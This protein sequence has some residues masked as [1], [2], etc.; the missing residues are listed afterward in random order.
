MWVL[1]F[2]LHTFLLLLTLLV[3]PPWAQA[4]DMPHRW[5]VGT[6]YIGGQLHW[7]F[8]ERW[9]LELRALKDEKA[10]PS[11]GTM[12]ASVYGLR[13]YRYFRKPSRLRF[14]AGIEGA[15]THSKSNLNAYTTSGFA[16][17]G[18]GGTEIYLIKRLS[19]GI[20]V[21]PYLLTTKVHNSQTDDSEVAI[22]IN[23][24]MNFYFL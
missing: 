19:V 10:D 6:T 14:Y 8:A 11:A 17:G 1:K 13:G 18:F 2:F 23:S 15:T 4:D 12:E 9:A 3:F 20:D 16:I 21:G 5:A 24:F 7:G 22:V